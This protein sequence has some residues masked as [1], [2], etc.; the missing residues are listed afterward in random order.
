M[1]NRKLL[2]MVMIFLFVS[3]VFSGCAQ[4]SADQAQE[5]VRIA[6]LNGPTGIGMVQLMDMPEK[7][8]VSVYQSPDEVAGKIVSGEVDIAAVPVNMGAILYNKTYGQVKAISP[9]TKGM[10]YILSNGGK[11]ITSIKDLAGREILAAAKGSTPEFIL[12]KLL[13]YN[14]IDPDSVPVKW[15]SNHADV[16]STLIANPGSVAMLPEPF[17]TIAKN[18]GDGVSVALDL[19]G[20]WLD[21]SGSPPTMSVLIAQKSFIEEHPEDLAAFINDY[22]ASVAFVNGDSDEAAALV[23]EKGF[24]ADADIAKEVI[25][26]CNIVFYDDPAEGKA[27]MES[28]YAI[29]FEIDQKSLGGALP[30]ADFY[31]QE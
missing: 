11:E 25:P 4:K 23:A 16:S 30:D 19:N 29:L 14:G 20:E 5:P 18:K 17:A 22:K 15:M 13:L 28:F 27:I 2:Y 6:T 3:V 12:D 26:R 9:V 31:Y 8:E 24:I 21:M 7:Y 10:L 1:K